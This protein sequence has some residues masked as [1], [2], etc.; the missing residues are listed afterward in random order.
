MPCDMSISMR[1]TKKL[2]ACYQLK[3]PPLLAFLQADASPGQSVPALSLC[4]L[5]H[6][7]VTVFSGVIV[8]T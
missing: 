4:V 8:S 7:S 5:K 2:P 6:N 3:Q 1:L